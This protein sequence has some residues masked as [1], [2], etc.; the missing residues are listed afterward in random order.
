MVDKI[1]EKAEYN[2][3]MVDKVALNLPVV[4]TRETMLR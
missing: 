4:M 3:I 2:N 1:S